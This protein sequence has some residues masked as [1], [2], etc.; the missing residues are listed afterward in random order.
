[1]T[2]SRKFLKFDC[3]V[4]ILFGILAVFSI[5]MIPLSWGTSLIAFFYCF[6]LLM[7]W[8]LFSA[9]L[10]VFIYQNKARAYYLLAMVTYGVACLF[11]EGT[12]MGDYIVLLCLP[13]IIWY[14][15]LTYKDAT[16]RTPSF[17]DLEF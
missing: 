16:Y 1:M 15:Y 7:M 6:P 13:L 4:H 5:V 8:Q 12:F 10:F 11:L 9:L 3:G 2:L 17:W 14:A